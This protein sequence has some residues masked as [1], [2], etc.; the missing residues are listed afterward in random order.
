MEIKQS[1][2]KK[3]VKASVLTPE[4]MRSKIALKIKEVYATENGKQFIAHLVRSF[5]PSSRIEFVENPPEHKMECA[6]TNR[7]VIA[8]SDAMRIVKTEK[9][10][11]FLSFMLQK[12][13]EMTDN[14]DIVEHPFD[15]ILNGRLLAVKCVGSQKFL[16]EFSWKELKRFVENEVVNDNKHITFLLVDEVRKMEAKK[17]EAV[18]PKGSFQKWNEKYAKKEKAKNNAPQ[19]QKHVN[20]QPATQSL[21]DNEVLK[22]LRETLP[23]EQENNT[24]NN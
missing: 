7:K 22:R 19:K 15:K 6:I 8:V 1:P 4:M 2:I 11:E 17:N 23:A 9:N 5:L 20:P 16:S 18:K 14:I 24:N 10:E 21:G 12:G 13:K 3:E